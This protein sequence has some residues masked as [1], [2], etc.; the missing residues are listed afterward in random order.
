MAYIASEDVARAKEMDLLTYLQ[1]YEP[2]N[3]VRLSPSTYCTK[4]H[5]SLKISNG[6]WHWYSRGIG[7]KSALDYLIKVEGMSLPE[8]AD[9]LLGPVSRTEAMPQYEAPPKR[10]FVLPPKNEESRR[11][12]AYLRKRGIDHEIISFCLKN[13]LL[14]ESSDYHNAVFVGR[15][16]EGTAKYAFLRGTL[17]P[18]KME[19]VSSD[20]RYAFCIKAEKNATTVRVF[21]S[22][23]DAMSY[24][25]LLKLQGENWRQYNYLS[26]GGVS[27]SRG[28]IPKALAQYL[29][30]YGGT[31]TVVLQLDND[32][33]GRTA[34][35]TIKEMLASDYT[36]T[37]ELP[38]S[39][40]DFNEYLCGQLK[41]KE[42]QER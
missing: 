1:I 8:A 26:L 16:S 22:A 3:L 12:Y 24:A 14:Y 19:A 39:G 30:D 4:E 2:H 41:S 36:V 15:N 33:A 38:P 7:G 13:E 9:R 17:G 37:V 40:K 42:Q 23:I 32:E 6:L 25:T 29:T 21:E 27:M 18:F 5:D 31:E 28:D 10:P 20:K 34:A 11:V 35:E